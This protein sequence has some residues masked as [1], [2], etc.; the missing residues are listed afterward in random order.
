M[1]WHERDYA[2]VGD[3]AGGGGFGMFSGGGRRFADNPLNWSPTLGTLFG[4]R[5]RIHITF[6]LYCVFEL[7]KPSLGL[8]WTLQWLA[9]LFGSVFLHELGHCFAARSVGGSADSVLMWPLGGLA[10]V[11]PPHLPW[12]E[13]VTVVCGP[14]VNVALAVLSIIVLIG[15][16]A[17]VSI[18]ALSPLSW[19]VLPP[20]ASSIQ[21]FL[22]L[23][24]AINT[25]LFLFNLVPMY[26]MDGGRM[27]HCA[28][29][30]SLGH[31]RGTM[32][33][34]TV[35][36]V[37]A[38]VMGLYAL[39]SQQYT[40][41]IIAFLGY[42]TCYQERMMVRAGMRTESGYMGYNFSQGYTSLDPKAD[43]KK[44]GILTKWRESAQQKAK[45]AREQESQALERYVDRILEK[46]HQH[47][48]GSLS[49]REKK[50]LEEASKRGR[51]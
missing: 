16:G 38:A 30:K 45:A 37:A 35:G 13:F 43:G 50:V 36:M 31:Q 28:L 18:S 22:W 41:L 51:T 21:I 44:K 46:V 32:A 5:I 4:I 3:G 26:P 48:I 11:S 17:Q 10:T 2:G 49:A 39:S 34:T 12:P 47:G 20:F 6:I 40:L 9:I 42:L 8:T 14:L 23:S 1:S 27:L 7:L 19:I 25:G 33:A 15:T 29:W 24:F